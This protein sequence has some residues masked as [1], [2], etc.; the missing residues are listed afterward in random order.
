M[1]IGGKDAFLM[2]GYMTDK[3][4]TT[5]LLLVLDKLDQVH[6]CL[7]CPIPEILVLATVDIP[8]HK[9]D[10][11]DKALQLLVKVAL[12]IDWKIIVELSIRIN[13]ID[14]VQRFDAG[15]CAWLVLEQVDQE[16]S[17]DLSKKKSGKKMSV[18]A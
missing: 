2:Q 14:R 17:N 16:F 10:H 11:L 4:L 8:D 3:V 15:L 13:I 1:D 18:N 5:L 12:D 6:G 9:L 7:V